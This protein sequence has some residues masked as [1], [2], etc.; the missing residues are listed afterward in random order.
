M[1]DPGSLSAGGISDTLARLDMFRWFVGLGPVADDP[2]L[3]SADQ[4][5]ANLEAFWDFSSPDSPHMPPSTTACYTAQGGSAAGQSN[6]D[7]GSGGPAQAIDDWMQ[8]TGNDTT[9]GHRR[10]IMY[11]PLDPI[12]IGYWQTG[13]MYGNS[14]CMNV[15]SASGTGPNPPWVAVPNPGYAVIDTAQ[16]T[17]SFHGSLGGLA[18]ATAS[19]V[20]VD[21]NTTLPV[22][23][24]PLSQGYGQDAIS[25]VPNGWQVEAGKTYQVTISGLSSGNVVYEVKPIACN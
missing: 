12:G 8:D 23:M 2:S 11:P 1:C 24:M 17:W 16:W 21:D 10:W 18:N 25:W 5:C 7:W 22:T 6:I 15:F 9:L 13:G 3:D 4:Q 19:V 20:R 14:A